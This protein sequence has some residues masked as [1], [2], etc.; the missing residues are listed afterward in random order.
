MAQKKGG[1][2]RSCDQRAGRALLYERRVGQFGLSLAEQYAWTN[3]LCATR[4]DRPR[5][6]FN[7]ATAHHQV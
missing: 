2:R 4:R 6:S 1:N 3:C 7:E 5:D